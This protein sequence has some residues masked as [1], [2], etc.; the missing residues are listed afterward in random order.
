ME[1]LD[2]LVALERQGWDALVAGEGG[3]YYREH[4]TTNALMAFPFGVLTRDA[5]IQAIESAPPWERYEL[6]QPRVVG[7]SDDSGVLVYEVVAQRAG[8]PP[9][10]AVISSAFVRQHDE[11]KLAFHQQSPTR[12]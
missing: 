1:L 12:H 3:A 9:Y 11:W 4:L 8:Q 5:T 10:S 6:R 2:Q 7:L